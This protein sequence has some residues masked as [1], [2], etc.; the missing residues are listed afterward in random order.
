MT[1]DAE[2]D[3]RTVALQLMHWQSDALTTRLD[4]CNIPNIN[5]FP[6]AIFTISD[7][8]IQVQLSGP[9]GVDTLKSMSTAQ[10]PIVKTCPI[11]YSGFLQ[12]DEIHQQKDAK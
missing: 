1:T 11:G 4:L 7:V 9:F 12:L 2:I 3:P 5:Y 6:I 10:A 8:V